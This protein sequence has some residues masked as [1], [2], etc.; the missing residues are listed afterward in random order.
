MVRVFTRE[1]FEE[2]LTRILSYV[3]EVNSMRIDPSKDSQLIRDVIFYSDNGY[4]ATL[5]EV[6]ESL[7][8]ADSSDYIGYIM[9]F[10]DRVNIERYR[11]IYE[12]DKP[13]RKSRIDRFIAFLNSIPTILN[14]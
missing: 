1:K 11:A 5:G 6:R 7:S 12:I 4:L 3:D 2:D 13:H 9:L 14:P 10:S 8:D